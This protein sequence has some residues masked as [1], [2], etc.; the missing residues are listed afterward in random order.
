[1]KWLRVLMANFKF[2][3]NIYILKLLAAWTFP[4]NKRP[5]H[6]NQLS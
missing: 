4:A 3:E 6:K 5:K 2:Y 1:M